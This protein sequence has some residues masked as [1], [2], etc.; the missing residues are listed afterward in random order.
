MKRVWAGILVG[1]GL[2]GAARE[3]WADV[4]TSVLSP[5]GGGGVSAS[6]PVF[7]G[8]ATFA[9]GS[10]CTVGGFGFD[11]DTDSMVYSPAAGTI[12]FCANNT[13]RHNLGPGGFYTNTDGLGIGAS[14]AVPD[15]FW[16]REAAGIFGAVGVV[17][18]GTNSQGIRLYNARDSGGTNYERAALTWNPAN[19]FSISSSEIAGTGT[20][21]PLAL[22]TGTNQIM[23]FGAAGTS[24]AFMS[25]SG[26]V[27]GFRI[28]NTNAAGIGQACGGGAD[29]QAS[30]TGT[31]NTIA[32]LGG[33]VL[34]ASTMTAESTG[35]L[36]TSSHAY[37]WSNAQVVALGAVTTGDIN[38]VTLPARTQVV[39]AMVVITGTAAGTTTLTVSCGD[40]TVGAPFTNLVLAGSAQAA[41]NTVYGDVL[42]E[43]G[44]SIDTEFFFL[45]SYTATT[46]VTCR[47]I[48]TGANLS[49][50]TGST[51][52]V[53]LTTRLLP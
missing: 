24:I 43:R 34:T 9:A 42:A 7:T 20:A 28:C 3:A 12:N 35:K 14:V 23:T 45:P 33:L 48:S 29:F 10:S 22:E 50:V 52:R 6:A 21:R 2:L 4:V 40:A 44:A 27:R 53:I 36:S 38:V 1:L 26:A 46:L 31:L 47:F 18:A 49:A 25:I 39:D 19:V 30:T 13:V 17:T 15:T 8:S 32:S 37:T 11:N 41:A 16:R 5:F 51:G